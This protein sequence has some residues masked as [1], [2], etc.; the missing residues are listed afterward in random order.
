MVRDSGYNVGMQAS[1]VGV[2]TAAVLWT[3]AVKVMEGLQQA[4]EDRAQAGVDRAQALY[5]AWLDDRL[6]SGAQAAR[7]CDELEAEVSKLK[8]DVLSA[9]VEVARLRKQLAAVQGV[10]A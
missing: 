2:T 10:A 1:A 5:D 8:G 7:R 4:R 6:R 9:W 3:G